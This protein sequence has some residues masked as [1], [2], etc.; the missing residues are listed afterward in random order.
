MQKK[1]NSLGE[2]K[3]L[4]GEFNIYNALAAICVAKAYNINLEVC[5]KALEKA[6]GI[7]GRME[8]LSENP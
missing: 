4:F 2:I 3:N 5:K 8:V 6:K 1:F 7:S